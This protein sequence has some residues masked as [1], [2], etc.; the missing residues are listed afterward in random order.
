[1][2]SSSETVKIRRG[3]VWLADASDGVNHENCLSQ[4]RLLRRIC[5]R[6]HRLRAGKTRSDIH[7]RCSWLTRGCHVG[8]VTTAFTHP[9]VTFRRDRFGECWQLI[10][11]GDLGPRSRTLCGQPRQGTPLSETY[12]ETQPAAPECICSLCTDPYTK[13]TASGIAVGKT[14][15]RHRFVNETDH[16]FRQ[17]TRA[18]R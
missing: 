15:T 16:R 1:V 11:V 7:R 10:P 13:L 9:A 4:R 18:A 2:R 14:R 3:E 8:D 17:A 5:E 6:A 12:A